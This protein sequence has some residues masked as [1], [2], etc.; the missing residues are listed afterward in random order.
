MEFLYFLFGY[1]AHSR[2]QNANK[3]CLYIIYIIPSK[4]LFPTKTKSCVRAKTNNTEYLLNLVK[5]FVSKK[6]YL[7]EI[8]SKL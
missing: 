3:N 2:I 8:Y 4:I 6:F 5:N 7:N 1:K